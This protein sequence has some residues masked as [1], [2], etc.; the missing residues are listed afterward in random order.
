MNPNSRASTMRE[1]KVS[2]RLAGR[3]EWETCDAADLEG[4]LPALTLAVC[5]NNFGELL[6]PA[7]SSRSSEI[8][9]STWVG[10]NNRRGQWQP[11]SFSLQDVA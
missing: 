9:D 5:A 6:P 4:T 10:W 8:F 1:V 3:E 11:F 2:N 7:L